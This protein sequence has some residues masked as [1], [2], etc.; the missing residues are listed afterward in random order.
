[1]KYNSKHFKDLVYLNV[2]L[3]AMFT[4]LQDCTI[5]KSSGNQNPDQTTENRPDS[6]GIPPKDQYTLGANFYNAVVKSDKSALNIS[7]QPLTIPAFNHQRCSFSQGGLRTVMNWNFSDATTFA[8]SGRNLEVSLWVDGLPKKGDQFKLKGSSHNDS[9]SSGSSGDVQLW[10]ENIKSDIPSVWTI[11]PF[12]DDS[13][14]S[15]TISRVIDNASTHDFRIEAFM[16]CS[17]EEFG[18]SSATK[19]ML[20]FDSELACTGSY[21]F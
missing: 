15:F 16:S 13:K 17:L 7:Q 4:V 1:M 18:S 21:S 11:D 20:S 12:S 9:I 6:K 5:R 3:I 2:L 8:H 19:S 10:L 14:C